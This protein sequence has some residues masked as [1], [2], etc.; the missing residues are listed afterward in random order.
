[1]STNDWKAELRRRIE[2][3]RERK[4]AEL[5]MRQGSGSVAAAP[6]AAPLPTEEPSTPTPQKHT[7]RETVRPRPAKK[8][9]HLATKPEAPRRKREPEPRPAEPKMRSEEPVEP[10][11]EPRADEAVMGEEEEP[12]LFPVESAEAEEIDDHLAASEGRE[13]SEEEPAAP[14][15]SDLEAAIDSYTPLDHNPTMEEPRQEPA[16]KPTVPKVEEQAPA[17]PHELNLRRMLAAAVDAVVLLLSEV[18]MLTVAGALL[19]R[20][21]PEL[22]AGSIVPLALLF[23]CLHFL[24]YVLFNSATGQTPGKLLLRLRI[25]GKDE[26]TRMGIAWA[27]VRWAAMVTSIVP[28][29]AGFFWIYSK[30]YGA[31]WHDIALGMKVDKV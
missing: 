27:V 26:S 16:V 31:A 11:A 21:L 25:T 15:A 18:L 7:P 14:A 19:E 22:I 23:V 4:E 2:V 9:L 5:D 10:V 12:T 6:A 24:Y 30:P 17:I 1:M 3:I 28:L 29:A 8:R 20:S 13:Q